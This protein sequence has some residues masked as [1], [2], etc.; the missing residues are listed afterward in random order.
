MADCLF[1]AGTLS[2]SHSL[3]P[4]YLSNHHCDH[5]SPF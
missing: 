1:S 3:S 2:L 5:Y 4:G